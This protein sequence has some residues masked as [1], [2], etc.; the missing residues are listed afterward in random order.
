MFIEFV[1]IYHFQNKHFGNTFKRISNKSI[2][3]DLFDKYTIENFFIIISV[4]LVY[5]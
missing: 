2:I 3:I 1:F 5:V 4:V